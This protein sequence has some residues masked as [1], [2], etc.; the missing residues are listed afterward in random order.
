M[1]RGG[2]QSTVN[3]VFPEQFLYWLGRRVYKFGSA[4]LRGLPQLCA[5]AFEQLFRGQFPG[6]ER[7]EFD[8]GKHFHD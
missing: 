4:Y 6:G 7:W 8:G 1:R 3:H 5:L 2:V